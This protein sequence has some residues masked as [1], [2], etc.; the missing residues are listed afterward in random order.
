MAWR[1]TRFYLLTRIN[2]CFFPVLFLES[3]AGLFGRLLKW[4]RGSTKTPLL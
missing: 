4:C 3:V 1:V 2:P